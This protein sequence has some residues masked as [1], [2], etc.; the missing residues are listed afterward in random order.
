MTNKNKI[1]FKTYNNL[2]RRHNKKRITI[3]KV[4]EYITKINLLLKNVK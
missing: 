3:K 1:E 2:W 4:K